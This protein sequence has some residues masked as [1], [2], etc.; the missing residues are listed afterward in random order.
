[1]DQINKKFDK[2]VSLGSNCYP[3]FFLKHILKN[4]GETHLFDYIGTSMWS[5]N[6]LFTNRF[7]DMFNNHEF[8]MLPL[9]IDSNPMVTNTRYNLRFPH[10]LKTVND[11]H[12]QI[13]KEKLLRRIARL[14]VLL[15]TS[16]NI[17]FIRY[18]EDQEGKIQYKTIDKTDYEELEIF[19]NF[20]KT[21]YNCKQITVIYI[22]LER[23]GW[24]EAHDILSVKIPTLKNDW[25]EVHN[26]IEQLFI[27]KNVVQQ[28]FS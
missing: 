19:I 21:H 3:K 14:N 23:D 25:A 18:Q 20:I 15:N 1:M 28:L 12:K 24:N 7:K 5:I 9:R 11:A 2:I 6:S 26:T 8:A 13:F 16:K 22:N 4:S 27:E 17:L 10:D